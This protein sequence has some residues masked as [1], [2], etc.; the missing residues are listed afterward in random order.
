MTV[1]IGGSF[2]YLG[3]SQRWSI[4]S[5]RYCNMAAKWKV[6]LYEYVTQKLGS[7]LNRITVKMGGPLS[8]LVG[9]KDDQLVP[10]GTATCQKHE[11]LANMSI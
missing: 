11:K 8:I 5:W 4:G 1:K 7:R 10:E 6:I 2:I 9:V 3:W